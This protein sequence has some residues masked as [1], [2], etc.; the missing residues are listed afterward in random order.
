MLVNHISVRFP[1]TSIEQEVY[2]PD[3]ST[4]GNGLDDFEYYHLWKYSRENNVV[5]DHT[6]I[7]LKGLVGYALKHDF[8][9]P[10]DL[11]Q[12]GNGNDLDEDSADDESSDKTAKRNLKLPSDVYKSVLRDIEDRT[13]YTPARLADDGTGNHRTEDEQSG[14]DIDTEE[15]AVDTAVRTYGRYTDLDQASPA[16][17]PFL[18]Q[19]TETEDGGVTRDVDETEFVSK[20]DLRE[21]YNTWVQINLVYHNQNS[22]VNSLDGVIE[23]YP[24]G[25]F[26]GQ[27]REVFDEPLKEGRPELEEGERIRS[28]FGITLTEKGKELVELEGTFS[29]TRRTAFST[30]SPSRASF[31]HQS[32]FETHR[33]TPGDNQNS[34]RNPPSAR[35]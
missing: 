17:K 4:S 12:F 21:A 26:V 34:R 23:E 19:H 11:E 25:A 2:G 1:L 5:P 20:S 13:G 24:I 8:C 7:P 31:Q 3:E 16:L 33:K 15:I 22:E 35:Q 10:D 30:H 27:F 32:H 14:P 9:E 28:W 29:T 18:I 6:P